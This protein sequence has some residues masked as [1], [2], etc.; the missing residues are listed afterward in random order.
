MSR[1]HTMFDQWYE[2]GDK[3]FHNIWQAFDCQRQTG[4]FPQYRFDQEFISSIKNVKRPKN[5]SHSYCKNLI[6]TRLKQLRKRHTYL[7]LAL[8]GGTDSFSILKYCVENDIYLDE[9][10]T[11]MVSIDHNAVRSN[12]EYLPSIKY[13]KQ[14]LG[15]SIGNVLL[16]HPTIKDYECVFEKDWLQNPEYVKG[17]QLPGRI[18]NA[19]SRWYNKTNLPLNESVTVFGL[20]KPYI[21][22]IEG[23]MYWTH[24]DSTIAEIM[25][26][27]NALPLFFDKNNPELHV[28]MT[29]AL[30]ENSDTSLPFIGY[31]TQP[32]HKKDKIIIE[33]GLESTGHYYIDHHLLGKS[34]YDSQ[35]MKASQAR[36]ELI[37]L[38]RQDILNAYYDTIKKCIQKYSNLPHALE[39]KSNKTIK[40]VARY[41]EKIPIY[42]DSFGS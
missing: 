26:C 14:H 32:T 13:A 25:G 4:T 27:Q 30:L 9:V 3:K 17:S 10:F 2:C 21:Q 34:A 33:M 22:N 38:D 1:S 7:R 24:L 5:L 36:K 20:D 15:K 39:I 12:I 6:V 8:G 11:Y 23:K 31:D 40:T 35:S 28:A 18:T 16:L 29:Y 37:K 19:V 42:Q 41:T